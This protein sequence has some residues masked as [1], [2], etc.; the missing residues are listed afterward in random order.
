MTRIGLSMGYNNKNEIDVLLDE[1]YSIYGYD[2]RH[3]SRASLSRRIK[4]F[5]EESGYEALD[6][7]QKEIIDNKTVFA[8]FLHSLSVTVT[9]FFRDPEVFHVIR[10]NIFE[11]LKTFPFIKIWH[12]GCATGEE[13]YSLAIMLF[14]EGLQD[15]VQVYATDMNTESL[16]KAKEGIFPLSSIKS[17]SENYKIS[18]G[19]GGL[20]D[21]F[22]SNYDYARVKNELKKNITF[23]NHNLVTDSVF[24][25]VHFI[26]CR[27]V[28]IYFDRDLQNKVFTLID[29]SL[30]KN[31]FLCLGTKESIRFSE[32]ESRYEE[33]HRKEKI[34]RKK[35]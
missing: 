29:R 18:G 1:I 4:G 19:D 10:N 8:S 17:F 14:E 25:E 20:S 12:A 9:E 16:R 26:L 21:Y 35:L 30:V 13:V 6:V 23:A 24:Q 15:K 27:N 22:D 3:Y 33:I 32:I 7:L 2:F 5:M 28:L 31:G 11:H 34:Y